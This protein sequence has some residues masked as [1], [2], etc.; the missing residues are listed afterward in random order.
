MRGMKKKLTVRQ[1]V[2]LVILIVAAVLALVSF[3]L[4]PDTVHNGARE[5]RKP[6]ACL[7]PVGLSVV[8]FILWDGLMEKHKEVLGKYKL[9]HALAFV[10]GTAF[11]CLGL[12]MSVLFLMRGL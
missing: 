9:L 10:G 6:V 2:G 3:I 12:L 5:V 7:F 11:S 8:C 1:W 4:L